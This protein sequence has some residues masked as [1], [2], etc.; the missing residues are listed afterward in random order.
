MTAFAFLVG[1]LTERSQTMKESLNLKKLLET[2]D[3]VGDLRGPGHTHG[4]CPLI[5]V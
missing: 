3:G 1:A 5:K 4:E 2:N